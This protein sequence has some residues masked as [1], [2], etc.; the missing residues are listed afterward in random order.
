[1]SGKRGFM[2]RIQQN[3]IF[4]SAAFSVPG[5]LIKRYMVIPERRPQ[6]GDLMYGEVAS[7]GFHVRMES[8]SARLHTIHD[9][10][11]A[12]FVFGTRYAPDHF[13]GVVPAR[14]VVE[15]DMLARSGVVGEMLT[16]NERISTPTR[17]RVLGY[18]CDA[19][20]EVVNTRNHV[21]L[22]PRRK[23]PE[24]K[25]A[26]LILCVGT[27]MNSGKSHTAAA[28]CYAISSMGKT[29][30]AAKITGTASLKDILLMQ[31]TGAQHVAD[32]TYFGHPS[33]YMLAEEDLL[34][35][36]DDVDLKYG[37]NPRNYLVMEF[38]DGIFQRETALLLQ[39]P[40]V[41][42]RIH[43]LVFCAAD[44][45]GIAGGLSVMRT[46]FDLVP[47]AISG[48]CSSSPLAIREIASFTDIPILRSMHRDFRTI[49]EL[50][51]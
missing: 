32:F 4:P 7:L 6:V 48:L 47:D 40:R 9:R 26:R 25:C 24:G 16:H 10:T 13:E 43:R 15:V 5:K 8:T 36:F 22:H 28:C 44:A 49:F 50:I 18:V 37:N 3:C 30:R 41:Q 31:D 1:M 46:T 2:E 27:A 23:K 29:V 12:V 33:T 21:L 34:R 42:E 38:A 14:P 11:R 20:G 35:I 19:D 17:I 51:R 39:H 45:A